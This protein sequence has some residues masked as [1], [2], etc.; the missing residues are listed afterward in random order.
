MNHTAFACA[1]LE[2]L[3]NVHKVSIN[4]R[5]GLSIAQLHLHSDTMMNPT[6][7]KTSKIK[8]EKITQV[9]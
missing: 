9:N 3:L 4:F 7:K 1:I 8:R 5:K 6:S 2:C